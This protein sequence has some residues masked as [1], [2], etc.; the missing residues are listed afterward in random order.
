M[1]EVHSCC[2]CFKS[3]AGF[4]RGHCEALLAAERRVNN[5]PVGSKWVRGLVLSKQ[6]CSNLDKVKRCQRNKS[7]R[8]RKEEEEEEM[9]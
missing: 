6:R 5:V 7:A 9:K 4:V 1:L 3:H 2:Y 8:R